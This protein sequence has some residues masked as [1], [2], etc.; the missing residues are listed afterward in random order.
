M[1]PTIGKL[2]LLAICSILV[3]SGAAH[4]PLLPTKEVPVA[5]TTL[6]V[7]DVI[8]DRQTE[9]E[10]TKQDVE[11]SASTE[12]QPEKAEP[13][14]R[15]VKKDVEREEAQLE[16]YIPSVVALAHAFDDSK[17][18]DLVEAIRQVLPKPDEI[19]GEEQ[20]DVGAL[21]RLSRHVLAWPDTSLSFTT[22]SQDRDGR[23]RWALSVNWP[24]P[25][26]AE[27][28]QTLL[29]DESAKRLLENV[30]L[31]DA[32]DNAWRLE[33]PDMVL[34]Y[35]RPT[36][37]GGAM[38]TAT[39]DLMPPEKIYGV[40]EFAD[41]KGRHR[42]TRLFCRLNLDAGDEG[43][44]NPMFSALLGV[45]SIDYDLRL[46]NNGN[47]REMFIVKWN[48][49]IGLAAKAIFQKARHQFQ[50]PKNAFVNAVVNLGSISESAPDAI[51]GLRPG[52]IGTRTTGEIAFS[53]MPGT[54]VIPIPDTYYQFRTGPRHLL[55]NRIRRAIEKDAATRREDDRR[56]A[57]FEENID[58]DVVFWRD[59]TADG[60]YGIAP[61]TFRT[62]IFFQ[63]PLT[64][65]EKNRNG[66]DDD[67][68][69]DN[70]P[71]TAE[72]DD[73]TP[74]MIVIANT[75]NWADDAVHNF[76]NQI[77]NART[78]PSSK[79]VDWQGRINW[80]GAYELAYPY[81]ALATGFS[82]DATMPPEPGE[83]QELLSDSQIDVKISIGGFLA[84][85]I[86]P[87]PVGGIYVPAVAGVTLSS[88]A[89]P[90]TEIAREQT[91]CRHLRVL[92]HH[93]KLFKN[94]YGRWPANVAELDGYID[95]ASHPELL[96]LREKN[97]NLLTSFAR[98][99]TIDKQDGSAGSD[100]SRNESENQIDDS[101]YVIDWSANDADW[102]LKLRKGEFIAYETIYIDADGRIH[103]VPKSDAEAS[104][105]D[106]DKDKN[107]SD[108]PKL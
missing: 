16:V 74:R 63:P 99:F 60:A 54:G 80:S 15:P 21:A 2:K 18:A 12:A 37:N 4:I 14:T 8:P 66:H 103:R 100:N 64:A 71:T 25:A 45:S 73:E 50:C 85:H 26:V 22:F 6:P 40:D 13:A 61:A 70:Q 29:A 5:T 102:K 7:R 68:S 83:V 11:V 65:E 43:V 105:N 81:V 52:T 93:A 87:V 1:G 101:L 79:K 19:P 27:R 96:Q 108:S 84:R 104:G 31:V 28:I 42:D 98:A 88:G 91:A 82:E 90:G 77:E 58:G 49:M 36:A 39:E 44:R 41:K 56:P 23:P 17:T 57:W 92:Y 33:L 34:A 86:G 9:P 10:P 24:L 35:L 48:A 75:S 46:L 78:I 67:E 47:W 20:F 38:L 32:G 69:G 94:D 59:P 89:S 95:F 3:T 62:V 72:S 97:V 53:L 107:D 106:R 76:R 30:T 51:T 55:V